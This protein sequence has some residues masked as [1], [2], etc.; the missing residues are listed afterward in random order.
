MKDKIKFGNLLAASLVVLAVVVSSRAYTQGL[1]EQVTVIGAYEPTIPEVNKIVVNPQ[2]S[3]TE[4][5]LPEMTYSI[6][7]APLNPTFS[8]EPIPP[9]KLVGEPQ[10]NLQR[11]YAKA[12]FGSYTSPYLEFWANSLRNQDYNFGVHAKHLSSSGKIK[13]YALSNNSLNLIDLHGNKFFGQHT[14]GAAAGYKRNVVHHYGFKPA[15]LEVPVN[16]EDLKQTFNRFNASVDFRSTYEEKDKLNHNLTLDFNNIT[17]RF[18]TRE[19]RIGFK[20]QADKR[21]ELF[22]LTDYQHLGLVTD[23]DFISYKDT[24]LSQKTTLVS[25]RPFIGTEFNQYSFKLGLNLTFKGDSV[26]KAYL[27]PYAE[28]GIR[29]IEDALSIKAGITGGLHRFGFDA[30]SSANP[31]VQSVLP[32]QYTR[33]RFTFYAQARARAGR[34]FNFAASFRA[35]TLENAGFFVNDF[36]SYPYNRFTMVYD[37]ADL[38]AGRFEAEYHKG[39]RIKLK[40]FASFEKWTTNKELH[41][42]HKPST[43][44]GAEGFYNIGDK[45]IVNASLALAGNQYAKK[46]DDSEGITV[47][48]MKPYLES[49]LGA[50]YRYTKSL[51]AFLNFNNLTGARN[52]VWYNYPGYRFNVMG[53]IAYSF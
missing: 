1:N 14:L 53:G 46:T 26:S 50:E 33:E 3:E 37:D 11:N 34:S 48:K 5:K 10:K 52:F 45:I 36:S 22:D 7:P 28:A 41:A 24:L 30:L 42:W 17:D 47:V 2:A 15:E 43:T 32:L 31:F 35:S 27:F 20:G 8:P 23:V 39:E 40:A 19:T 13:D 9:V 29:V 49:Q 4:V 25:L 44:I 16:D 21:F 18:D 51:S 6:N 38:L 12:G